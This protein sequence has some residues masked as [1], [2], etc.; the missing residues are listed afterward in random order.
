MKK[1][2]TQSAQEVLNGLGV[3]A[4]GLSTAEALRRREQYGP[5]KLKEAEKELEGPVFKIFTKI[6]RW[7]AK[8]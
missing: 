4:E 3:G 1:N 5:N 7:V 2:Y 8:F 6:A